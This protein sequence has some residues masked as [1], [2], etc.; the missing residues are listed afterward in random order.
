MVVQETADEALKRKMKMLI[1]KQFFELSKYLA[2]L[3][4]NLAMQKMVGQEQI[5]D[6]YQSMED[7]VYQNLQGD[8]LRTRL[9]QLRKDRDNELAS[10]EE[11]FAMKEKEQ[12]SSLRE[13]L[14][15]KF[16]QEKKDF[17]EEDVK[18]RSKLIEGIIERSKSGNPGLKEAA[19]QLLKANKSAMEE[20]KQEYDQQKNENL[21][22]I[23]L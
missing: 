16:C 6:K 15:E 19:K 3:Y 22:K 14:E 2:G 5:K 9:P 17:I 21:E 10:F 8:Q 1:N 13:K 23:K 18:S 12:E 20:Q 4:T 7:E 11:D